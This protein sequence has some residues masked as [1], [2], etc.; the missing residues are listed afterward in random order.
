[1]ADLDKLTKM[2][3]TLKISVP[4]ES[5]PRLL[6]FR[7]ELLRWNKNINLTAIT[8][9]NEALEKHLVDSL[10]LLPFLPKDS[11][12]LDIGSGGG[13][14]ALPLKIAEPSLA[15][16]SVDSSGK[17]IAFQ[18]HIGRALSLSNF[19]ALNMRAELLPQHEKLPRFDFVVARAFASIGTILRLSL[20]LLKDGGRIVAMKGPEADRELKEA[21]EDLATNKIVCCHQHTLQLPASG[22]SRSLMFFSRQPA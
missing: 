4:E 20:P 22:A 13:F 16:W 18:N 6:W 10:T 21:G 11:T 17:K 7:D 8:D 1:M 9:P 3:E 14:P 5:L 19:A 2:L 12:L 15:V